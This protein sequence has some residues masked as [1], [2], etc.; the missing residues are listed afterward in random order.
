MD[1]IINKVK[2]LKS[3][4]INIRRDLHQT[5]ELGLEEF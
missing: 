3:W 1:K 2:N 5:P 4:I